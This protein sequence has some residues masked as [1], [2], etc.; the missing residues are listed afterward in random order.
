MF[1]CLGNICRSPLAHGVMA[2]K[3][4]S[5]G[6]GHLLRVDSCGTGDWHVGQGAD[7][8]SVD[9]A[10][11]NGVDLSGHRARRFRL[12]DPGRFSWSVCMDRSNVRN[13]RRMTPGQ[14]FGVVLL[15]DF[16]PEGP[17]DVPDPWGRGRGAFEEVYRIV[18][19]SCESLVDRVVGELR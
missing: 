17:G 16:D 4:A 11:R 19:R 10:R 6:L 8:G 9:V 5:R 3:V 14:D 2:A 18:D 13:V 12:G 1:V 7:P 15:R